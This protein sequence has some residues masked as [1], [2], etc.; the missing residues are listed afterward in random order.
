MTAALD[1]LLVALESGTGFDDVEPGLLWAALA[2]AGITPSW[3]EA[4][5]AAGGPGALLARGMVPAFTQP[6]RRPRLLDRPGIA[7]RL[8]KLA[9]FL[10]AGGRVVSADDELERFVDEPVLCFYGCGHGRLPRSSTPVVAVVGSRDARVEH[11][12]RTSRVTQALVDAGVTIVSGGAIGIDRAAQH[13]ARL[14]RGA[15]V[16]VAGDLPIK[17]P[18]PVIADPDLCWV[19][20]HA[21]WDMHGRHQWAKRNTWIAAAADVVIV[22]CGGALSGTRHTVEAAVKL[23]RPVVT[24]PILDVD[25]PLMVIPRALLD[26]GIG[27]EIDD[28]V[29]VDALLRLQ[30]R[31]GAREAFRA[32]SS[33]TGKP[34]GGT[35]SSSRGGT[36]PL[37]LSPSLSDAELALDDDE[38]PPLL[39]LL[40]AH[41]GRLLIDEAA[42]RLCTTMRALLVD[43]AALELDGALRR[44]GALLCLV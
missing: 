10:S 3:R 43:A 35:L 7:A 6:Q 5:R 29:D 33:T 39:R 30:P 22:V 28:D 15:F 23:G 2:A 37:P 40:R 24:L 31:V 32:W 42:A 4:V 8:E 20:P 1:R 17:R 41:G 38:A 9:P 14:H 44:E 13:T 25:D 18:D 26:H 27:H 34:R 19:T 11:L 12:E 21:P 36:L 16:V